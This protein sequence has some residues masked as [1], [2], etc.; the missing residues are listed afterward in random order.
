M[1]PNTLSVLPYLQ[2]GPFSIT[3]GP[4]HR[5]QKNKNYELANSG[6]LLN[7]PPGNYTLRL[8]RD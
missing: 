5:L 6:Q 4:L 3:L 2:N 7:I 1:Y 8:N